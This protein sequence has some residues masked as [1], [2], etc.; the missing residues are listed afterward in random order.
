VRQR[1]QCDAGL[2]QHAVERARERHP[3][4]A[5]ALVPQQ[6]RVARCDRYSDDKAQEYAGVRCRQFDRRGRE[7]A[8]LERHAIEAAGQE[9]GQARNV[10]RVGGDQRRREREILVA[11]K[12]TMLA[13]RGCESGDIVE[14]TGECRLRSA[15][16]LDAGYQDDGKC[17][18]RDGHRVVPAA[19]SASTSCRHK[20]RWMAADGADAST[21][22]NASPSP[23]RIS[24]TNA[25]TISALRRSLSRAVRPPRLASA[26][27]CNTA[28][29]AGAAS[30]GGQMRG[31]EIATMEIRRQL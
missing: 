24:S 27:V 30:A 15:I 4:S 17:E 19:A 21:C 7:L 13:Q 26:I 12:R 9:R 29:C 23:A 10:D 11:G 8:W 31:S 3:P 1:E 5:H 28:A 18:Q 25:T 2:R 20:W 14:H 22:A 16:A 6:I